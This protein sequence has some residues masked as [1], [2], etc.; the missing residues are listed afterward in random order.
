[1]PLVV[2][3]DDVAGGAVGCGEVN[4]HDAPVNGLPMPLAS[5][6]LPLESWPSPAIWTKPP[7][8]YCSTSWIWS[9]PWGRPAQQQAPPRVP[10]GRRRRPAR[11]AGALRVIELVAHASGARVLHAGALARVEHA[12]A[13]VHVGARLEHLVEREPVRVAGALAGTAGDDVVARV[14]DDAVVVA[15]HAELVRRDAA[16]LVDVVHVGV[17]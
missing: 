11:E 5:N 15:E 17:H 7:N 16:A 4:D 2:T 9:P 14:P 10:R 6:T 1:M 13:L 3:N 12:P 8:Q